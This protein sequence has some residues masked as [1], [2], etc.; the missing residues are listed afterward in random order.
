M[1]SVLIPVISKE[2]IPFKIE[3]DEM[4][5]FVGQKVDQRWLWHGIDHYTG[6]EPLILLIA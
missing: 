6:T 3:V 4:Q 1:T 2:I 5:S